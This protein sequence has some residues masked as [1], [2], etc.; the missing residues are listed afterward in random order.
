MSVN[1]LD[2]IQT[3][4]QYPPLQKIDPNTQEVVVNDSTPN[5]HRF[6][7]A[8]IP[9]V[10]T[11]LYKYSTIDEGAEKLL[12]GDFSTDWVS[13]IFGD[14]KNDVVEKVAAYS[15]QTKEDTVTK[16]NDIAQTAIRLIHDNLSPDATK[17]DVKNFMSGQRNNILLYLP[18]A[19]HMGESLNDTT[20]D[21]NTN[22]ME[23]PIS[24][25]MHK[26]GSAFSKPPDEAELKQ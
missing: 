18:E 16:M 14:T 19:L 22:K 8:S 24:S 2:T 1:L 9:V 7:Q 12:S 13:Q 6:S 3:S 17:M 15:F 5:E 10:L 25:L 23:G 26:I 11:G 21:D 20:L 4:L